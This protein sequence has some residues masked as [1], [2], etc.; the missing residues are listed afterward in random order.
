MDFDSIRREWPK[1]SSYRKWQLVVGYQISYKKLHKW[2]VTLIAEG[3]VREEERNAKQLAP[4]TVWQIFYDYGP[5]PVKSVF[6]T[7]RV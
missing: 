7:N 4:I 1:I 6:E 2:I 3:K 5:P